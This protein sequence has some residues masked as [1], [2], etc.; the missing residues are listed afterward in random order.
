MIT[1]TENTYAGKIFKILS[2]IW[3]LYEKYDWVD[4]V[5]QIFGEGVSTVQAMST[6]VPEKV[7]A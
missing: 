2:L 7:M 1:F 3:F 6:V 4:E 5:K